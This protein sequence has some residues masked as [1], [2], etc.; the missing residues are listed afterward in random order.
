MTL[1]DRLAEIGEEGGR[2]VLLTVVVG[3]RPGAKLL[4]EEGGATHG[5]GPPEL[6]EQADALIRGGRNA[7]LELGERRV[8][9]EVYA[10]PPR[11][12]IYGAVD[13]AEYI[14]QAVKLVGWT[15]IVADARRPYLTRERLPTPDELVVGWPDAVFEQ[16]KPDHAT[17]IVVLTHDAKFD[18]PAIDGALRSEAFYI[19]ALGSRRRQEKLRERLAELGFDAEA[20]GRIKGPCGLDIGAD[21][22]PET[23][24]SIVAE[25]L[26]VRSGRAGGPLGET[27][28]RIH[29]ADS[30]HRLA[31]SPPAA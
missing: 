26:A 5:D 17:A 23:A 12:V 20:I 21:T 28:A 8:L 9:A 15:S 1:L 27:R 11:V 19:G 2:A 31:A 18:G 4:V 14:A 22:Q 6:A 16:V 7:L 13:T 10:P 24:V 25:M 29:V 30:E 3:D